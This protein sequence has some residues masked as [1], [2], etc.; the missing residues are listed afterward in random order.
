MRATVTARGKGR[1]KNDYIFDINDVQLLRFK[2]MESITIAPFIKLLW[3]LLSNNPK[4]L[5]KD[6]INI[7]V[8]EN[9][10]YEDPKFRSK[11]P[12]SFYKLLSNYRFRRNDKFVNH[13][14]LCSLTDPDTCPAKVAKVQE[15]FR[16]RVTPE[17]NKRGKKR[18][19]KKKNAVSSE[20]T[21]TRQLPKRQRV[22]APVEE[23]PSSCPQLSHIWKNECSLDISEEQFGELFGFDKL[24]E[25][26]GDTV[27]WWWVQSY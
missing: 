25:V 2:I 1:I 17:R 23:F 8:V 18:H 21:M 4:L 10:Y 22:S 15:D 14:S 27:Q 5:T 12:A 13:S 9:A 26:K 24:F 3:T 11:N 16:S 6:G 19:S 7:D 20:A